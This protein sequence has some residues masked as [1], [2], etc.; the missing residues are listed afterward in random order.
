MPTTV[1]GSCSIAVKVVA[2]KAGSETKFGISPDGSEKTV[3][4]MVGTM[5]NQNTAQ[6]EH[7]RSRSLR[8]TRPRKGN[9]GVVV[10]EIA[11]TTLPVGPGL[12]AV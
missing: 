5:P 1:V 6:N 3:T 10:T 4:V 11:L 2:I 7:T 9:Q 12:T 8:P